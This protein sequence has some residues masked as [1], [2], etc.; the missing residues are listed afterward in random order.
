MELLD[1]KI[2]LANLLIGTYNSHSRSTLVSQVSCREVLPA[3]PQRHLPV[4]QTM[5][6]KCRYCNTEGIEN[7]TYIKYFRQYLKWINFCED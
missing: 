6:R 5:I 7:K 1:F 2:V 3:S 4:L